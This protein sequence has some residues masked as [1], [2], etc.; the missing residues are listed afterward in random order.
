MLELEKHQIP[1]QHAMMPMGVPMGVPLASG[2]RL[3]SCARVLVLALALL[4][5]CA[6]GGAL[7]PRVGGA[8]AG[9]ADGDADS[10]YTCVATNKSMVQMFCSN[11]TLPPRL[12]TDDGQIS[13]HKTAKVGP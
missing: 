10:P 7:S 11:V 13:Y 2:Q 8:G 3:S 9:V 4:S 5:S 12:C 6:A 1:E